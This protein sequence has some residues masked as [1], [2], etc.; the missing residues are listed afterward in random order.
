MPAMT[1]PSTIAPDAAG[2]GPRPRLVT[3]RVTTIG[4]YCLKVSTKIAFRPAKEL[5]EVVH[6]GL[7]FDHKQAR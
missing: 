5:N 1:I 3:M 4:V 2:H 6:T 7:S